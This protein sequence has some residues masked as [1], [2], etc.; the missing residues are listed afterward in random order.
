M[1]ANKIISIF[2]VVLILVLLCGCKHESNTSGIDT[3][4][5]I[6]NEESFTS[7]QE[8]IQ[9][10]NVNIEGSK[11]NAESSKTNT[12][13]SKVNTVSS[14]VTTI[15][16]KISTE[17]SKKNTESSKSDFVAT[18]NKDILDPQSSQ[19]SK[20]QGEK[21]EISKVK[22][23]TGVQNGID[24]SKWQ[25]KI[26]WDKVK[27]AGFD[28]AIIRIGYRA[29][30]GKIYK[31]SYADYN[32][33]QAN[34]SGILVGVYFFSTAISIDEAEKE[35][36]WV[37]NNVKNYP[38]SLPVA[39][40]CEGFNDSSSRMF[41]LTAKNRT[42]NALAFI[43]QIK[44]YGYEGMF[45][46]AKSDLENEWETSR[47][48]SA[49]KIWVAHYDSTTFPKVKNPPYSGKYDMWQYTNKGIVEG[50]EG[51][52]DLVVS[53]FTST[54]KSPKSNNTVSVASAPKEVDKTYKE[55]NEKVTAKDIVNLRAEANTTSKIVGEIKIGQIVLRTA[56]GSNGWSK[57]KYNGKTVYAISSYLTTDTDYKTPVASS[58]NTTVSDGYVD[59]NDRVTPKNEVNLRLEPT[60]TSKTVATIKNGEILVRIG[61]NDTKG[62]SKILY[63]EQ[64]VYAVSSMLTTDLDYKYGSSSAPKDQNDEMR[65][66]DA[67]EQVTAKSE[68]NLRSKPVGGSGSEV[69]YILKNGEYLKRTGYSDQGWSRLEWDGKVVY[70]VSSYL[71]V[72]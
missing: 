49:A 9:S 16:S 65:F 30:N 46:A 12:E 47:L 72:K 28:F 44:S 22:N 66:Y 26:S 5:I 1:K 70:A 27:T 38:I 2:S 71:E 15:S 34:K 61:K 21:V 18:T 41:N 40:D 8:N 48:E 3:T 6:K 35:A 19:N 13:S 14:K 20:P 33:Q 64:T 54:K 62:W 43:K 42:D 67:N 4:S 23:K 11:E 51:D 36:K 31:D 17:S 29:E 7:S 59:V 53:Y 37:Y 25:G 10:S 24:V 63:K 32:I 60:T 52:T 58:E 68:T 56:V 50:I 45:Y 57:L 69:V 55:V 39:Y